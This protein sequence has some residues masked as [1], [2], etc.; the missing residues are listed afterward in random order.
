MYHTVTDGNLREMKSK[1]RWFNKTYWY[2]IEFKTRE[3][4]NIRDNDKFQNQWK[5]GAK[6]VP[7]W[8][9][10]KNTIITVKL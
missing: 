4:D 5:L 1:V 3:W 9:K 8:I 2:N 7:S 6:Q 10:I